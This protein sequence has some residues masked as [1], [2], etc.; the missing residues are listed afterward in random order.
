MT[1]LIVHRLSLIVDFAGT[2]RRRC[3]YGPRCGVRGCRR[4]GNECRLPDDSREWFCY[5]HM[6]DMGFCPGCRNFWAGVESFDFSRTGYCENCASGEDWDDDY[7]DYWEDDDM[8][9]DDLP[10]CQVL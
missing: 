7:S 6:R 5:L 1:P 10:H 4:F 3:G 9:W 8:D 2:L